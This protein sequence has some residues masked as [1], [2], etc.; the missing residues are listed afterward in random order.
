MV[1]ESYD[2]I[3]VTYPTSSSE[4]YVFK[5]GGSGGTTVATVVVTY[6]SSAKTDL[7]SVEK[8]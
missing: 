5:T 8:T 2:Y 6:T 1:T 4:Q 3:A 7:S